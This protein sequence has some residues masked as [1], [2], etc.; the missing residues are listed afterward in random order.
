MSGARS[1]AVWTATD[2]SPGEVEKHLRRLVVERHAEDEGYV[3]AR[4]L[5]LVCVV[6]RDWSGEIANRLR[7]V[8]RYHASRTIVCA[9]EPAPWKGVLNATCW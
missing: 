5:N 1:D 3:P 9:I 6:D 4:A 7:Q 8:G 2:T